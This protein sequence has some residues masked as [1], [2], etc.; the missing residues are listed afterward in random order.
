MWRRMIV[1]GVIVSACATGQG[2]SSDPV[3][4]QEVLESG[5]ADAYEALEILRP[6]WLQRADVSGGMAVRREVGQ[7]PPPRT[8]SGCQWTAYIGSTGVEV[9]DL[10]NVSVTRISELRLIQ[11]R[12]RRP[13]R[14]MC[15]HDA[16]AIHVVL[17]DGFGAAADP[18]NIIG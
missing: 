13:D 15:S 18:P 7:P 8:D 16:P 9:E 11:P 3:T 14:S 17:L 10:R 12:A 6:R 2:G 5:A 1:I 4:R